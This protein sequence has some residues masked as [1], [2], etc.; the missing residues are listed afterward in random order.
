MLIVG[1]TNSEW[2]PLFGSAVDQVM[3]EARALG[4]QRVIWLTTGRPGT[5]AAQ[6]NSILRAKASTN[7]AMRIADWVSYSAGHPEWFWPDGIHLKTTEGK[8]AMANMLASAVSAA[9]ASL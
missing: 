7:P 5:N 8:L 4:F 3:A 9:A 2:A 6:V 1:V